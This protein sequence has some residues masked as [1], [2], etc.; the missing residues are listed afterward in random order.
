MAKKNIIPDAYIV[1]EVMDLL[2]EEN[3]REFLNA[4][5][6]I[7]VGPYLFLNLVTHVHEKENYGAR[8]L[9]LHQSNM[10]YP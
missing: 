1:S 3:F 4:I 6:F 9:S 7:K 10:H 2:V 8:F 5:P